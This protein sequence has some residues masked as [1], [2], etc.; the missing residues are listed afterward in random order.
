MPEFF[1]VNGLARYSMAGMTSLG[2]IT[3][4]RVPTSSIL[5]QKNEILKKYDQNKF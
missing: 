2:I 3:G 5:L 1:L 4:T